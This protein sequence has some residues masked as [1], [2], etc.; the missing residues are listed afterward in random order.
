VR[1][2]VAFLLM[3]LLTAAAARSQP[4][5]IRDCPDCPELVLVPA[6][7]FS[8]G[9]TI[10]EEDAEIVPFEFRGWAHPRHTV[11]IAA[12]FYLGMHHV[13]RGEF[14]AFV[15]SSGH[16]ITGCRGGSS[17][18][19]TGFQQTDDDP[20]VCVSADDADAY[21]QWLI[22]TTGKNYRLPSEAEWEYAARAGTDGVHYWR[23]DKAG[24]CPHAATGGCGLTGTAPVGRY[25]PNPFGL[26][27]MLGEAWQWTADCWHDSY[28]SAPADGTAW[29]SGNCSLRVVRGGAWSTSAWQLRAAERDAYRNTYR[30]S[31]VGFRVARAVS[32]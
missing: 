15:K 9:A 1:R 23:E 31:D 18:R 16:D 4:Q 8:M 7:S 28:D 19:A 6:G 22:R 27:D 2:A 20:V 3:T 25:P 21:V 14:A 32:R 30:A 10:G 17:W 12:P 13:T 29:L 5:T 26:Q 24:P 11:H